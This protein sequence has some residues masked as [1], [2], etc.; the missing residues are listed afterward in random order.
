[1]DIV[2]QGPLFKN[3]LETA[4]SYIE[5]D[6]ID[7]I[8]VVHWDSEPSLSISNKNI[9]EIQ[10]PD[11]S[12][13]GATNINRQIVS[14]QAGLER[15]KNEICAKMRSDQKISINSMNKMN[16][17]FTKVSKEP[18]P[19]FLDGNTPRA[20]IC[21]LGM[22]RK[23]P[24]HPQ[25]HIFWGYTEDVK[26]VFDIPLQDAPIMHPDA[27]LSTD[28]N[29]SKTLRAPVTLGVNYYARFNDKVRMFMKDISRYL[30][31]GAPNMGEALKVYNNFGNTIFRSF[32][33]IDMHWEKY[34]SGYWYEIYSN[35]G[36]EYG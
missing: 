26:K 36:E 20:V 10:I 6:F 3:T 2:L 31:D 14:T 29:Y 32:P 23:Y 9:I 33:R 30:G 1:M 17:F 34:N 4:K 28:I 13:P 5:C 35:M 15:C 7:K 19:S 16:N 12:I 11:V 22:N 27:K 21:V 25:D 8:Y 24:F 18:S